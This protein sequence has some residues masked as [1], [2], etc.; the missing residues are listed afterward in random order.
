MICMSAM[1]WH[2]ECGEHLITRNDMAYVLSCFGSQITCTSGEMA[3]R[4]RGTLSSYDVLVMSYFEKEI[5]DFINTQHTDK[6]RKT[7]KNNMHSL[8]MSGPIS[9]KNAMIASDIARLLR[10]ACKECKGACDVA[11]KTG[12]GVS[13]CNQ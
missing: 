13:Y 2:S 8:T 1:P 6:D 10:D 4:Y 11:V 9:Q 7:I 3:M 12:H 5:A